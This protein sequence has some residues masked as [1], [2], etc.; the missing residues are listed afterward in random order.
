MIEKADADA[1]RPLICP[2]VVNGQCTA[3]RPVYASMV[4]RAGSWGALKV[5]DLSNPAAPTLV[6]SYQTPRSRIFPP[7]DLGV[8]AP[9]RAVAKGDYAYVAW[10]SDGLR[11]LDVSSPSNPVELGSFVPPDTPDPNGAIPA[12]A[13]VQGVDTLGCGKV[14][15][16]DINS[17]LYVLNV[18]APPNC[19]SLSVAAALAGPSATGSATGSAAP[20]AAQRAAKPALE[21]AEVHT[22]D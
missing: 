14:V 21:A 1:L 7:P 3:H 4:D 8:Y 10:N 12:K 6:G 18:P 13:Y 20:T 22:T 11:V 5:L 19:S 15:I 17:G 16:T 9:A 2:S